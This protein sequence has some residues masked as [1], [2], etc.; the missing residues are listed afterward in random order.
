MIFLEE[1]LEKATFKDFEETAN[2]MLILVDTSHHV[3]VISQ[4]KPSS[5]L[6]PTSNFFTT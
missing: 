4:T 3:T 2:F 1:S 6:K 5:S